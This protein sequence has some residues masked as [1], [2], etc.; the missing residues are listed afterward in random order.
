L[1]LVLS[2]VGGGGLSGAG[3]EATLGAADG[4]VELAPPLGAS[5]GTGSG[6]LGPPHQRWNL[7]PDGVLVSGLDA[8]A[9][10]WAL[11]LASTGRI[12][13]AEGAAVVLV[14]RDSPRAIKCEE[15]TGLREKEKE[16]E[17]GG[18][19]RRDRGVDV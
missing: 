4:A 1:A 8:G 2:V 5:A 13:P 16:R 19:V 6:E 9:G 3:G 18:G 12:F 11:G 10:Q 17:R 7:S 15:G 14:P